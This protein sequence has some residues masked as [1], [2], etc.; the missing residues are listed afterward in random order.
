MGN[1]RLCHELLV[2]DTPLAGGHR[3]EDG[4]PHG[5]DSA[6]ARYRV[7]AVVAAAARHCDGA[8]I[9]PHE[10][11]TDASPCCEADDLHTRPS[12]AGA[13]KHHQYV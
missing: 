4:A 7:D 2:H 13:E 6:G 11:A 10:R 3:V 9:S 5:G 12:P 8:A 1:P